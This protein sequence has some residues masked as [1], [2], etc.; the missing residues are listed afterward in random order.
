MTP[1]ELQARFA[2]FDKANPQVWSLF[3]RFSLRAAQRRRRFG[4]AA[5]FE[6]IRWE[7]NV[8]TH[9]SEF[10]LNNN[11]RA[12]YARKFAAKYPQHGHLFRCRPSAADG[13]EFTA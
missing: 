3:E 10:K 7:M 9:G 2:A 12:F 8:E 4:S 6:R 11:W 5:V 13:M 1:A